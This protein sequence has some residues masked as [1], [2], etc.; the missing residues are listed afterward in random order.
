M[1]WMI[2]GLYGDLYRTAMHTPPQERA[3]HEWEIERGNA[4]LAS[5]ARPRLLTR[6][7]CA[8]AGR[9]VQFLGLPQIPGR[10]TL[11]RRK[12]AGQFTFRV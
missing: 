9:V 4:E 8:L 3:L 10:A 6:A 7:A 11:R 2:D 5:E 1:M 12:T